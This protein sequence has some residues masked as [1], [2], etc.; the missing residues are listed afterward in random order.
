MEL[1]FASVLKGSGA[2]ALAAAGIILGGSFLFAATRLLSARMMAD[3]WHNLTPD[4]QLSIDLTVIALIAAL[5]ARIYRG[6]QARLHDEQHVRCRSCGH[7]LKETPTDRG[8]GRC[9]EC[10]MPFVRFPHQ[11]EAVGRQ[12]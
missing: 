1:P 12:E 2:A 7:D 5:A 9:G 10:G 8:M 6:R 4:M 11:P 3:A